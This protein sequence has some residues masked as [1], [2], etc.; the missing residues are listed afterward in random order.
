MDAVEEKICP[1]CKNTF[2][3]N[4]EDI[5]NCQCHAVTLSEKESA[6]LKL[7]FKDCLC[8]QCLLEIKG[9]VMVNTNG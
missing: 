9:I 7:N 1:R 2:T 4:A 3:C 6:F 8:I 5:K